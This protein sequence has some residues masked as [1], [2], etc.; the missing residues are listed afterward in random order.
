MTIATVTHAHIAKLI[1]TFNGTYYHVGEKCNLRALLLPEH[2]L[3][4]LQLQIEET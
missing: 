4:D 1:A 2:L 3:C